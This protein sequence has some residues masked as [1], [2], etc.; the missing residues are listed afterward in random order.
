M[1]LWDYINSTTESV[2]QNAPDLT[3]VKDACRAS[4]SYSQAAVAKIDNTVRVNGFEKVGTY[5]SDAENRAKVGRFAKKFTENAADYAFHE[6]VKSIPGGTA[7]SKI[8]SKTLKDMNAEDRKD[9]KTKALQ[10][11]GEAKLGSQIAD[12]KKISEDMS[13]IFYEEGIY[14]WPLFG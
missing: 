3:S 8:A 9:Q 5:L 11:K 14:G 10:G 2:K 7:V 6:G 13:I 12:A 4:Y 1:G